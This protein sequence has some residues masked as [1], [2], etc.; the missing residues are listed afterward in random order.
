MSKFIKVH[1]LDGK[2]VLLGTAYIETVQKTS[3]S[4]AAT[5]ITVR[6]GPSIP[7][8]HL[9]R[10]KLYFARMRNDRTE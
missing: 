7:T 4:A 5:I 1:L 2:P 8:R 10:L 6:D 9:K 3:S